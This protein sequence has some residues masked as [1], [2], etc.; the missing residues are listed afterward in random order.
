M[1]CSS[2]GNGPIWVKFNINHPLTPHAMWEYSKIEN[3]ISQKKSQLQKLQNLVFSN[4]PNWNEEQ[5]AYE[6]CNTTIG[7]PFT[8]RKQ[9]SDI[10]TSNTFS[11]WYPNQHVSHHHEREWGPLQEQAPYA[12]MSKFSKISISTWIIAFSRSKKCVSTF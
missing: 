4:L 1:A 12:K 2:F 11:I 7:L 3:H 9:Q 5:R 8:G 10:C 6:M